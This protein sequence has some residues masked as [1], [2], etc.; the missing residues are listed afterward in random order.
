MGKKI[1]IAVLATSL[2]LFACLQSLYI[3]SS[4]GRLTQAAEMIQDGI[5]AQNVQKTNQ[6]IDEFGHV[7][8]A[9]SDTWMSLMLH[10]HVDSVYKSYLLLKKY[11]QAGD[12]TL[13]SVYLTQLQYALSDVNKLDQLNF[14]NIF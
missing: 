14:K 2:I 4:Y 12:L 8:E 6:Y 5:D 7:W 3:S 9:N 13:A 11:A 10:E 1:A